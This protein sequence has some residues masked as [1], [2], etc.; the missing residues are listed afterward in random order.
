MENSE[1]ARSLTRHGRCAPK[2]YSKLLRRDAL[3]QLLR[4]RGIEAIILCGFATETG[5][6]GTATHA[7]Q[8]GSYPVIVEETVGNRKQDASN[9]RSSTDRR[10][11]PQAQT[12]LSTGKFC[13][14]LYLAGPTIRASSR[15]S[16]NAYFFVCKSKLRSNRRRMIR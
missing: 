1:G 5:I 12:A 9:V 14:R 2:A 4:N 11:G 10:D 13:G 16:R 8:L 15:L 6:E 7:N 3:E